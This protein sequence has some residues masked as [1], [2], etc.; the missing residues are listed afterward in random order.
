M[1]SLITIIPLVLSFLLVLFFAPIWIRKAKQ[2]G[3]VWDDKNKIGADKVA[4]SGGIIVLFSFI[5]S[6]YLFVAFRT[7]ILGDSL[8]LI[9]IISLANVVLLSALVGFMDDLMGWQRG[10]LAIR[11][12]IILVA[13]AAIPLMAINAGGHEISIPFI[14]AVN[15]GVL[16]PLI[17]IP[18]GIVATTTTFNFLAG[19]NGLEAGQGVILLSALSLVAFLTGSSWLAVAGLCMVAALAAFLL[20][21]SCPARVFPGDVLTYAVGSLVGTM[22][23]LG[24]FEK[25]AVFFFVPYILEVALKLRGG[26]AKSSF[27][28]PMR[29]GSLELLHDKIYGST[30]LAIWTLKKLGITPTEK[31][32]VY[33]IWLF[34]IIVILAGFFIFGRGL[35]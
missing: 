14:G 17:F 8:R 12:R 33:A 11:T 35:V 5:I 27:G 24:N 16:Y 13:I 9:E 30:H 29:D 18:L 32:A 20:Y 6:I 23:I 19:F 10:G 7:F 21:N 31:R 26:L 4:G 22:A 2:I 25:I 15:F 3:L 28:R 34:Q 1:I